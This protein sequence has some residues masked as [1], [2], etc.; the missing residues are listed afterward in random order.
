MDFLFYDCEHGMI[1]YHRLEKLI[2]MG[3]AE[4]IPSIVRV[5]QLARRDV[6]QALDCGADGVMV[7]MIETVEQAKQLVAWSKYPPLGIRSYS[8]RSQ[9]TLSPQRKPCGK[10]EG[11]GK[12]DPE[13]C[14]D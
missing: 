8:R 14:S 3:N 5:A 9:Y 1:P 6:S 13:H 2:L 12:P 4:G 7:P 11:G 10:Y